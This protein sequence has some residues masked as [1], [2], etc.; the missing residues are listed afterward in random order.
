MQVTVK[1]DRANCPVERTLEVIGGRW[2]VLILRE[3]FPGVKRFNELQRAVNGITQKMLTQQLREMESDGVVHREV[4][5]QVPP[6]V[7]YSLTALG[8]SLKPIIDTMHEW[9]IQHLVT[10]NKY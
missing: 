5:L 3:L 4:Y 1:G 7:E 2:K 9:G 10:T 8:E 6:K